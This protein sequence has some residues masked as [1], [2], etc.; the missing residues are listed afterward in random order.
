MN[1]EEMGVMKVL[2]NAK[3]IVHPVII[4]FRRRAP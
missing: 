3:Y 2:Y 1:G 4:D